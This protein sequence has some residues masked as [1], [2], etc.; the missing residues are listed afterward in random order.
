MKVNISEAKANQ[1]EKIVI[2]KNNVPLVD[3]VAHKIEAKRKLGLLEGSF[4]VPDD[5]MDEQTEIS[6]MFYGTAP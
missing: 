4:T 2:L 5:L 1:G 6:E 3:M